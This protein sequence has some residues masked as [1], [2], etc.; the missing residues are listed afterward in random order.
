MPSDSHHV[1]D[2]PQGRHLTPRKATGYRKV[3]GLWGR[4]RS[5]S[6]RTTAKR[7][8]WV[9]EPTAWLES[10]A[11]NSR[12]A[13][14]ESRLHTRT[15]TSQPSRVAGRDGHARTR[16][17]CRCTRG[18]VN[19]ATSRNERCGAKRYSG[20]LRTGPPFSS[21][22]RQVRDAGLRSKESD[23]ALLNGEA[24]AVLPAV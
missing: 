18:V 19:V 24:H 9:R 13:A 11:K 14:G 16:W 10:S 1:W 22:F 21:A 2:H 5:K 4:A 17:Q 20:T 15:T 3:G 6:F 7:A 23:I 8:A 12:G